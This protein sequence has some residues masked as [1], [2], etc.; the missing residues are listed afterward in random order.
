M[1]SS[2]SVAR[3]GAA[4]LRV[5]DLVGGSDGGSGHDVRGARGLRW[6]DGALQALDRGVGRLVPEA[7][8]PFLQAGAIANTSF[9]IAAVTG[10]FLLFWYVPSVH[11]AHDSVRAMGDAPWTAGL[12]RS[13]HRYSSD[14]CMFFVLLHAVKVTAARR[15]AGAR[16]LSWVSGLF[17]LATLWLVGWLGYWLVWDERA[18]QVAVGTARMMDVLPLFTDPLSRSFVADATVN[19]LLFF[20]VFFIHCLMPLFMAAALW[21]HVARLA[22]SRFFTTRAMTLWVTGSLVL[23]SVALPADLAQRASVAAV[24]GRMPLDWWYL[25]PVYLTDRLSGGVLWAGLLLVGLVI[26]GVPWWAA[27]R[28]PQAASVDL[29]KC[30]ACGQCY[31]DCPYDAIVMAPRS[32]GRRFDAQ[33]SVQPARCVGCGI[34]SGSCD[35]VGIGLPHHTQTEERER[36][37][38][39]LAAA[40]ARGESPFVAFV[41]TG[42][43]GAGLR[44]DAGSG[45]SEDLPGYLVVAVPC[46]GWVHPLTIERALRHGAGGVLVVASGPGQ[47]AY[48]E[49]SDWLEERL[50]GRRA[51]ALRTDKIDAA[52][53]RMVRLDPLQRTELLR[54]AA[55]F[56]EAAPAR[57]S[58]RAPRLVGAAVVVGLLCAV[59]GLGSALPYAAPQPA[60]PELVLSFK[61][62]GQVSENCRDLTPEE[63]EALPAHMRRTRVC[64]RERAPVRVRVAVAGRAVFERTYPPTGLGGDGPS[65]ALATILVPA[66]RHEVTVAIGDTHDPEAWTHEGHRSLEFTRDARRA[67]VFDRHAGFTWY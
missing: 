31:Q 64:E 13:L 12:L 40:G 62:P 16:W 10:V 46:A 57:R 59:V 2:T 49:G 35:S 19:S 15:F 63:I 60:S 51:P 24:P 23:L 8:N 27:R 67:V 17:L 65:I 1:S 14:G 53:V 9:I 56:R 34:C 43:A 36:I 25:A 47:C 20:L 7:F 32:D 22:R 4:P 66:G 41:C 11:Q 45:R 38:R 39:W 58:W 52:S 50:A 5:G 55:S 44:V 26:T 29:A 21:L 3:T 6:L 42:S 61:H 30:N 28:R 54:T 33:A 18:R 48:R 37:D